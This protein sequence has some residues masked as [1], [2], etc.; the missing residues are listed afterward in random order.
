M[1]LTFLFFPFSLFFCLLCQSIW[2]RDDDY[3]LD[4]YIDIHAHSTLMNGFMYCNIHDDIQKAEKEVRMMHLSVAQEQDNLWYP[5]RLFNW[6]YHSSTRISVAIFAP[7][8]CQCQRILL[9]KLEILFWSHESCEWTFVGFC[10]FV[11]C[12]LICLFSLLLIP[13][14]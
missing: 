3:S 14:C 11:L 1:H 5:R 9:A 10:L 2:C 13:L 6:H 8:R 12:S 7:V 4:F